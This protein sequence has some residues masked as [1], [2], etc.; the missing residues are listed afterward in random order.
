MQKKK[1]I[2]FFCK[3]NSCRS[4]IAEAYLRNIASDCFDVFSAG[5]YPELIHPLVD[6]VMREDRIDISGHTSKSIDLYLGKQMF[7]WIIIVCWEGEA[8][9]PQLYPFA[10]NT[11]RWPMSDPASMTGDKEDVLRAFRHTRDQIKQR[12]QDWLTHNK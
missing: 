5:L 6:V 10:M 3:H 7:D 2:L 11:E 12:V 4:Q 1:R 8:G 9:C